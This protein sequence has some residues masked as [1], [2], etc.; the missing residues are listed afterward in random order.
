[1]QA[2]AKRHGS[3]DKASG[4]DEPRKWIAEGKE[5]EKL[6]ARWRDECEKFRQARKKYL[7]Y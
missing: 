1:M 3:F 4:S 5:L 7:L 2:G 6:F